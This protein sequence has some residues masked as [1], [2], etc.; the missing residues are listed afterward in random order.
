[1]LNDHDWRVSEGPATLKVS[2]QVVIEMLIL[3]L[4]GSEVLHQFHH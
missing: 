2:P 4:Y 3:G 1:M